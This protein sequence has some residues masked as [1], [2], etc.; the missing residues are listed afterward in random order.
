MFRK[1]PLLTKLKNILQTNRPSFLYP[2]IQN[3]KT[4]DLTKRVCHDILCHNYNDKSDEKKSNQWNGQQRT[5]L[6]EKGRCMEADED[7]LGAAHR[8]RNS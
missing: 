6:A 2:G 5:P 8:G 1:I 4:H 3:I 7:G